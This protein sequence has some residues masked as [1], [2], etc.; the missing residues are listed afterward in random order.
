MTE[1]V[2]VRSIEDWWRDYAFLTQEVQ[3]FTDRQSWDMVLNLLDQRTMLQT[4]IDEHADRKFAASVSGRAL[5]GEIMRE[6][7]AISQKMKQLRNQA[8]NRQKI[9]KAYDAFSAVPS[10]VLLNRGT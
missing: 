7:Q 4:Q 5:I 6:E 10:G 1:P 2:V 3:K 8:E 9:A